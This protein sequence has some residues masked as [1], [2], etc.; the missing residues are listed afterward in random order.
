MSQKEAAEYRLI[1]EGITFDGQVGRLRVKYPFIDDPRKL[2]DNYRQVL[3]IAESEERKLAKE[4][5]T[6]TANKLFD[7]MIEVGA[8]TELSK[9]EIDMW[10]GPVHYISIQ[11]VVDLSSA[12][13]PLRLVTNSSLADPVTGI[14]L[15]SI[16]AKGP[17]VLNDMFEIV[18]RFRL[19][20]KGLISDVSKAYYMLLTG[21]LEKHVRRV[22]W[23]YGDTR[24][25]WRIFV[26]L[27][28]SMGDR[29]AACLMELAVKLTVLIFGGTESEV[30]R[31]KGAEN[32]ETMM[33]EGTMS[34]IMEKTNLK[35][36]AV[37]VTGETDGEKLK[38]LGS[39]VL[40]LGFSTE[41]DTM[42]VRCQEKGVTNW[43]R[44]DS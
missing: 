25:R 39:S 4:N 11:H 44:L 26:F 2:S 33:C 32:I 21:E 31:F 37:A 30:A 40:G 6:G 35:L 22:L 24:S 8:V 13:T 42:M 36:K 23:R 3:R 28:A 41:R 12:T 16:L 34:Q 7:K 29:P 5:L 9:A 15:N 27:S 38:K 17:K 43:T 20:D 14:S 10:D 19:Y 1:E 18:L